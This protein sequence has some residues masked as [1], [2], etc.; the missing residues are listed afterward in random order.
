MSLPFRPLLAGALLAA[1][2]LFHRPTEAQSVRTEVFNLRRIVAGQMWGSGQ[3]LAF[4]QDEDLKDLNGD[5]DAEDSILCLADTKALR[6]YETGIAIDPALIDDEEDWPVAIEGDVIVAQMSELDNG[7]KDLNGNGFVGDDVLVMINSTN[8]QVTP[9]GLSGARPVVSGGKVYCAQAEEDAKRDLNGDG[10]QRDSVLVVYDPA[11]RKVESLGM[12]CSDQFQVT[13]DWIATA[14]SEA[15]HFGRDLNGD[16]DAGDVV[17]QVYQISQKKW[18][19]TALE[20]TFEMVLT[21]KLVAVG[22]AE[23]RQGNKDLNGDNDMGDIVCQVWDLAQARAF[24]TGRDCSVDLSAD[25]NVVGFICAENN[26]GRTDLNGNKVPGDEVAQAYVLGASGPVNIGRDASG[27]LITAGG[28]IAFACSETIQ[29]NRD[30]N[31]DKDADDLVLLV[32]DPVKHAVANLGYAVDGVLVAEG[33]LLAFR[34][35]EIDQGDRDLN[36]DGDP[37]DMVLAVAHLP[38][39]SVSMTGYAASEYL[40]VADAWISFGVLEI[41]QGDRDLN[42]NGNPDDEVLHLA[43]VRR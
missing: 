29:G 8:R 26:Q 10:D 22:T 24:N 28:K 12:E 1:V 2:P 4:S 13:G 25:G 19:N 30:L 36:R 37:D 6:V 3:W 41:D 18:T 23:S 27:G 11:T 7:K 33:D 39:N 31:K 9:I 21:P 34:V 15:A 16:N 35:A 17:C 42:G 40:H 20:C 43:R 38:T 32:Y 5:G 14:T